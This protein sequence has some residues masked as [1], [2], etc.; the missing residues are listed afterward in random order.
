MIRLIYIFAIIVVS[1]QHAI[2]QSGKYS[3]SKNKVLSFNNLKTNTVRSHKLLIKNNSITLNVPNRFEELTSLIKDK[4]FEYHS[5]FELLFGEIPKDDVVIKIMDESHFFEKTGAPKWTNALY[6]RNSVMIPIGAELNLESTLKALKHEYLHSVIDSLTNGRCP[7]WL[8][9]GLAQW[10]EGEENP[11]LAEAL[12]QWLKVNQPV[13]LSL[14]Q[15]GFTK[16]R[17]DMVPAAYAQSLFGVNAIIKAF[18]LDS[19][20][21]YFKKLKNGKSQNIAFQES[22]NITIVDYQR[23]LN[24][25]LYKWHR[26]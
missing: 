19:L 14:L 5:E 9:E 26:H 25:L 12:D 15:G 10:V 23:Y 7:G 20:K 8:D 4:L 13:S 2:A 24:K 3:T 1:N 11:A 18:G 16:L 21:E 22:F 17:N 6:Y